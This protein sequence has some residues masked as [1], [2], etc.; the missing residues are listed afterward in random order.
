MELTRNLRID[1]V[2]RLG[3]S[4]PRYLEEACPVADAVEIMRRESVGCLLVTRAGKL[5]G[6]FTERDLLSRV[7]APGRPMTTILA[8]CLTTDPVTVDPK[9]T[10]KTGIDR[11]Q[12][13]GY[14]HLPVVTSDG[15]PVGILSAKQIVRYL[16]EHF[17]GIVYNLPPRPHDNNPSEPEGA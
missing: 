6:V 17:P 15:T 9:D 2:T 14:R 3:P 13:G 1:S 4:P 12:T 10:V 11:M 5:V 7:L 8:D 16:V